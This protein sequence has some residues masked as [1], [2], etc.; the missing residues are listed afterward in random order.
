MLLI[1][2]LVDLFDSYKNNNK[3]LVNIEKKNETKT[4]H[5]WNLNWDLYTFGFIMFLKIIKYIEF[6]NVSYLK[7]IT[8]SITK[9]IIILILELSY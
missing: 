1:I 6:I 4:Y 8:N 9:N 5:F 7:S 3:L 2:N